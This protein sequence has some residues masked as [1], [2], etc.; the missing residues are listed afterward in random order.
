MTM[1]TFDDMSYWHLA[2]VW[3]CS[4]ISTFF[5]SIV[6]RYLASKPPMLQTVMDTANYA[7]FGAFIVLTNMTTLVMTTTTLAV[8]SGELVALSL[9]WF[10]YFMTK[11]IVLEAMAIV[12]I[13]LF[14]VQRP[15]VLESEMF[16]NVVRAIVAGA[17]PVVAS[18]MCLALGLVGIKPYIYF[19]LRGMDLPKERD[20]MLE[21]LGFGLTSIFLVQFIASRYWIKRTG[22]YLNVESNHIIQT[23]VIAGLLL[24]SIACFALVGFTHSSK[25]FSVLPSILY[26]MFCVLTVFSHNSLRSYAMRK[27]PFCQMMVT[28]MHRVSRA[29]QSR[30]VDVVE[31]PQ[32]MSPVQG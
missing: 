18:S 6:L 29:R 13:Q 28:L 11:C 20:I 16:E 24:V 25:V 31:A 12:S 19:H 14:I 5:A 8:D 27:S 15:S 23:K 1:T 26:C 9:T 10:F 4:P 30:R 2:L 21:V 17:V 32:E 22:Y 3:A 7:F